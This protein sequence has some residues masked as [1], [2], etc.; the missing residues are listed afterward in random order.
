MRRIKQATVLGLLAVAT[1]SARAQGTYSL[2]VVGYI[3][4]TID[5][6]DNLIANQLSAVPDNTLDSVFPAGAGVLPGSTFSE[7]NPV[8]SQLLPSSTFNG[9][10]WSINY[11]LAP[12]GMGGVLDSPGNTVVTTSGNVVNLNLAPNAN[13]FYT[14][15]PPVL[16]PGTYLLAAAGPVS[17]GTFNLIIGSDPVAGDAVETLD[18]LTQTYTTTT[19]NGTTWDNGAPS[20]GIDQSAYF[21][22]AAPEPST[23]ALAGLGI[24][25]F[26][27]R[28]R[29]PRI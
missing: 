16:S 29:Q 17:P 19:F 21:T 20:L 24:G 7:W 8:T 12:N 5:A 13:P 4:L 28:F 11:T 1:Y 9:T 15:V 18:A 25:L 14:F 3:N 22:L 27:V 10:S 26:L 23:L 6:G 2:N